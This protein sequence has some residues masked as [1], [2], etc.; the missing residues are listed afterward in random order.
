MLQE[1][2]GQAAAI[3]EAHALYFLDLAE[4]TE[5]ELGG[6]AQ[7]EAMDR[8]QTEHENFQ[9]ALDWFHESGR[10]VEELRL[11]GALGRY[12][13]VRGFLTEGEWN[14]TRALQARGSA[15]P[16]G[17]GSSPG[18]LRRTWQPRAVSMRNP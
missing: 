16:G 2:S 14:V 18:R 6:A 1:R 12:W 4:Q 13:Q 3:R 15:P 8:L 10:S 11:C 7:K 17:A 9:A 5:P